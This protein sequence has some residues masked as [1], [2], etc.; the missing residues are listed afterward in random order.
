M[1]QTKKDLDYFSHFHENDAEYAAQR[2][3][4]GRAIPSRAFILELLKFDHNLD[5]EAVARVFKLRKVWELDALEN[6]LNAMIRAGTIY[7]AQDETLKIVDPSQPIIGRV[8]GH[9]EGFGYLDLLDKSD[10]SGSLFIPPS[11]MIY[12]L[13]GD[14]AE[15]LP[16]GFDNRNRRIAKITKIVERGFT[17]FFGRIYKDEDGF[18]IVPE[19]RRIAR[20]FSVAPELT[21]KARNLD[22]VRA[23]VVNYPDQNQPATAEVIEVFGD[24]VTVDIEIE[25]ALLEHDIPHIFPK[26]VEAEVANLPDAVSASEL[27]GRK[28]YRDIPLVTIDGI[29]ARDF[30]DAVY[31]EPLKSGN[32]K[33]IVA[34]ADVSYYVKPSSPIDKEAYLRSTSVYFPNRVIPMLHRALSNGI[35]SLNPEVDRLCMVAEL[36]IDKRGNLVHYEFFEGVM[37]SHARLTYDLVF[38]II[39]GDELLRESY[40]H[41]TP[42][43][44]HLY[45]LYKILRKKRNERGT[46]D[47]DTIETL[48]LYDNDGEIEKIVPDERNDAHKIIEECM[49]TANIA[50]AR[51]LEAHKIPTLYR[52][53]APPEEQKLFK[54]REFLKEFGLGLRGGESP[55]PMD[56]AKTLEEA[57]NLP[58]FNM[59]QTVMLRSLSQAVY[60]PENGGHFGLS[61][62]HYAHFTSPIRRYPDLLVHRA[63]KHLLHK[64][65]I[66]NFYTLGKMVQMGEHTSMAERRADEAVRDVMDWL[67]AKYLQQFIGDQFTGKITGVTNFGLFVELD[68]IYI[69]GLVHI[70][71]LEG[72]FFIYDEHRHRLIGERTKRQYRL[73]DRVRIKVKEANPETKHIDFE[74]LT[75]VSEQTVGT[76]TGMENDGLRPPKKQRG[77]I[78]RKDGKSARRPKRTGKAAAAKLKA[79][80]KK[81]KKRR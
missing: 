25:Q 6:R 14:I 27:K 18:T 54:L 46:I 19:N 10:K 80:R 30:D 52:V 1:S 69:E 29:T 24:E 59:I 49:I 48:I 32:Y 23:K 11:E 38:K 3:Q 15:A 73:E 75:P 61:L 41:L 21:K 44:D 39:D 55:S 56:F 42:H 26:E 2:E 66:E 47:F 28:D 35:C 76:T 70:S 17:E 13:H 81:R 31:C 7:T 9:A 67:K 57:K 79:K 22:I 51:F 72:D 77:E 20:H 45:A 62:T 8:T 74:L 68:D 5:F 71:Q 33:L 65:E 78:S 36:E 64:R 50:A 53:H 37:N 60:Q 63:I 16:A 12:L 34:I 58:A 4:Y 43:L 40:A